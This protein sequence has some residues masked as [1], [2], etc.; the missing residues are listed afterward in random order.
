VKK[1]LV[2]KIAAGFLAAGCLLMAGCASIK[3]VDAA[4][5]ALVGGLTLDPQVQWAALPT[6]G[7]VTLWTIDGLGLDELY[8]FTNVAP[9]KPL[10]ALPNVAANDTPHYETAMLPDDVMELVAATLTKGGYR[11][12][13][14]AALMPAP[15][16]GGAGFRFTIALTTEDGLEMKG[17]AYAGQRAGKLNLILFLAPTEY[18]FDHYAPT[19]EKMFASVRAS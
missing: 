17:L 1:H 4:K 3:G 7:D 12:V 16:G 11:Q 9:G 6:R 2:Y 10:M 19:V 8:F 14:T 13:R 18:Y 15:F 5:P